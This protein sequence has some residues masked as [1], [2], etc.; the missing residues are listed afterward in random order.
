MTEP[1]QRRKWTRGGLLLALVVAI[2]AGGITAAATA[3]TKSTTQPPATGFAPDPPPMRS[4][5]QWLIT[6]EYKHGTVSMKDAKRI[7]LKNPV[8]TPRRMG[9][10]AAELLSGPTVIERHRFD[11]PLIGADEFAGQPRPPNA[12]PSFSA[13]A[14]VTYRIMLPDTPRASQARLVDRATGEVLM[15]PWPPVGHPSAA[16]SNRVADAGVGDAASGSGHA[17]SDGDAS[18][19]MDR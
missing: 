10:Y 7:K 3:Q 19:P 8:T 11:F 12:P 9:R 1:K 18:S 16:A 5:T 2:V 14:T 6:F 15:I 13:K 17:A 4:D